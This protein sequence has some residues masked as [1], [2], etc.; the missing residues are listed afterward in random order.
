MVIT[1]PVDTIVSSCLAGGTQID[2]F[3]QL[4]MDIDGEAAGDESGFS[5]SLSADGS[6]VAIGARLNDGNGSIRVTRVCMNGMAR[7]G[8]SWAPTSM[9]KRQVIESG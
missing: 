7:A 2:S 8:F 5:V 6:R 4:G 3:L 1:C 9:A